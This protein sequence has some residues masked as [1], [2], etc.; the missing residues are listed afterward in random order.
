MFRHVW[1]AYKAYKHVCT[2]LQTPTSSILPSPIDVH[3]PPCHCFARWLPNPS[4]TLVQLQPLPT[5]TNTRDPTQTNRR[6]KE[7]DGRQAK[8]TKPTT[9]TTTTTTPNTAST[10]TTTMSTSTC[11]TKTRTGMDR[12][13]ERQGKKMGL[14]TRL[15]SSPWYVFFI[16][17][18]EVRLQDPN[19]GVTVIWA[20]VFYIYT[21]P[22]TW[23]R[24]HTNSLREK[25]QTTRYTSFGLYVSFFLY[26]HLFSIC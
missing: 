18:L 7:P 26:I 20:P 12:W 9:T 16:F 24:H 23:P 21:H 10:S 4:P 3:A 5:L 11:G 17:F 19:N 15:V 25:A 13:E 8:P 14:E 2:R 22:S 6:P 1:H